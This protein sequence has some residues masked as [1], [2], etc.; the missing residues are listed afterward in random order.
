[1][2]IVERAG[3]AAAVA[4]A[5]VVLTVAGCSATSGDTSPASS[6]AATPAAPGAAAD[7]FAKV[8]SSSEVR[9][10]RYL[11]PTTT[12]SRD[13]QQN[14][15]DLYLPPGTHAPDSVP[16]V[17]LIH[18]GSWQAQIGADSFVALSRR[19]AERGL[20]VYNVEYRRVGSGGGWPTTFS[21]VAA[22]LDYV[23]R[24]QDE[25][26]EINTT[27]AVVVGHSA[28]GQLAMWSGTRNKLNS[29]EIGS[30][31][32]FRPTAVVSLAGP[33]DMIE[34]VKRGDDRIVRALGGTPSQVPDR[35]TSVDPI[36][37]V[38]PGTPVVAMVGT[39]DRVVPAVLSKNYVDAVRKAGG[40]ATTV[41][42]P[43]IN[44]V[45]IVDPSAATFPQVIET[46]SR[47]AYNE[48]RR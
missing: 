41:L 31:P 25:V 15:A 19:L 2:R 16:L 36:Q 27:N 45:T 29:N 12:G 26:E 22:A 21:D 34:A 46:I 35:Y 10:N 42:L 37:N 7:Q 24:I 11:Y 28:G 8:R 3:W 43:G 5:V 39:D 17:V 23:P 18:G 48:H 30:N 20:A 47:V 9:V 1:M 13:D 38:D 40:R 44:H 6:S 33:L 32:A 14:W 4:A